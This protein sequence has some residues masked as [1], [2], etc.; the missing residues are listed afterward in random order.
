M[1]PVRVL[2]DFRARHPLQERVVDTFVP[3]DARLIGGAG[4]GANPEYPEDGKQWNSVLLCTGANACGKVR[5][6][7]LTTFVIHSLTSYRST[8]ECLHETSRLH[9]SLIDLSLMYHKIALIQIMAQVGY[10]LSICPHVLKSN[11]GWLVRIYRS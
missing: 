10:L 3:N 4:I 2:A 5:Y 9:I 11:L 6:Q 7:Y 8:V 1:F